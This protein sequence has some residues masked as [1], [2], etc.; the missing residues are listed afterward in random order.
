MKA[1]ILN[2]INKLQAYKTAIKNLHWASK[3]MSEHKLLDE[4]AD[5]LA[6]IQDEIAEIAQGIY[7]KIK[8]NQLKPRRYNISNSKKMLADL[9]KDT[10]AF[11]DTVQGKN[12]TGLRSVIESFLGEL[13]KFDYLMDMCIKEDIKRKYSNLI[14]EERKIKQ[15]IRITEQ[16]INKMVENALNNYYSFKNS[17]KRKLY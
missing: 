15:P 10:K 13:N 2:Y 4:I 6:D 17:N 1:N 16:D 11:C 7:G 12:E 8:K 14:R 5:S 3:K 9:I